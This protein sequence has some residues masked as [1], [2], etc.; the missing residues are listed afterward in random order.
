MYFL[1]DYCGGFFDLLQDIEHGAYYLL[2]YAG[3]NPTY[4]MLCSKHITN[5]VAHKKG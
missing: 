2:D 1:D 4:F 3:A 5:I